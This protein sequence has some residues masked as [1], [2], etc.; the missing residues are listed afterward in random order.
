V[1]VKR[2]FEPIRRRTD[3][4]DLPTQGLALLL[5]ELRPA[6]L[7]DQAT[8]RGHEAVAGA[9]QVEVRDGVLDRA[10][11]RSAPTPWDIAAL[12]LML[13]TVKTYLR[14]VMHQLGARNAPN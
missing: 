8:E 6:Q 5:G 3:P 2:P 10:D 1:D 12:P 14:E 7:R 13:N 9:D 4:A 11:G